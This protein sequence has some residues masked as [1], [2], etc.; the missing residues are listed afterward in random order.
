MFP[1]KV[2]EGPGFE[3]RL[4]LVEQAV[5]QEPRFSVAASDRGLFAEIAEELAGS[6]AAATRLLFVCGRDAAERIVNWD[7]GE[8]GAFPKMLE[9]FELLVAA[10]GGEYA[11]PAEMRARIHPLRLGENCDSIS[12]TEVRRRI[13]AGLP[14]EHLVPESIVAHVRELYAGKAPQP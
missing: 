13:A 11:P 10:R 1:H 7:Y 3:Q 2:Y 6:Y 5:A 8:A 12:A 9:R 14:W 4:R